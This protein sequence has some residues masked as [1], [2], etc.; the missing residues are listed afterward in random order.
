MT[1]T[2]GTNLLICVFGGVKLGTKSG[3][4]NQKFKQIGN[5]LSLKADKISGQLAKKH[6]TSIAKII[7]V[8][9]SFFLLKG[10][11]FFL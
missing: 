7:S 6:G 2:L 10:F 5:I 11:I 3:R 1:S 9:N 8:T 4:G